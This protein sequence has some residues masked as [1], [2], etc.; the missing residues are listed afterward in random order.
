MTNP[1]F[2][3]EAVAR[4]PEMALGAGDEERPSGRAEAARADAL[5]SPSKASF[6]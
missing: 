5:Q 4:D 1:A 3:Y 6:A 2:A